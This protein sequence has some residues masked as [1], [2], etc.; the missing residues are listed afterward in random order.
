[1]SSV[2]SSSQFSPTVTAAVVCGT[3]TSSAPVSAFSFA[4]AFVTSSV[5]SCPLDLLL[6]PN[7]EFDVG[8]H[9][10]RLMRL[11]NAPE[12]SQRRLPRH[13]VVVILSEAK[14]A[15]DLLDRPRGNS[16]R[17]DRNGAAASSSLRCHPERRRS[18]RR[19][20]STEPREDSFRGLFT[21]ILRSLRFAQDDKRVAHAFA[22]ATLVTCRARGRTRA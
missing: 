21:K 2:T 11:R 3:E 18:Q 9:G 20:Y 14:P 22:C 13:P 7:L 15:K 10:G 19:I 4:A 8:A 5:M 12:R 6:R 1:M 16:Y 17:G